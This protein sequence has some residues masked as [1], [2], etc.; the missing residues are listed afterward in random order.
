MEIACSAGV[1]LEEAN[2]IS[3]RSFI[4]PAMFHLEL[5]WTVGVGGEGRA[6]RRLPEEAVE[7]QNTLYLF[8]HHCIYGNEQVTNQNDLN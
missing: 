2:V 3:S 4:R 5:G 8:A 6:R 1:L 7:K